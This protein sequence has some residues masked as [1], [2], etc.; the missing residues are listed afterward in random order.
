MPSNIVLSKALGCVR[1]I[2]G[3]S[4][5]QPT[6]PAKDRVAATS[7]KRLIFII[8]ITPRSSSSQRIGFVIDAIEVA[9]VFES[10]HPSAP[11]VFV[12]RVTVRPEVIILG[13]FS[14]LDQAARQIRNAGRL[15][16]APVL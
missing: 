2:V 7:R 12:E 11:A 15:A 13:I 5:A 9:C 10:F 6:S 1:S 16:D 14:S 8:L 3:T 4:T